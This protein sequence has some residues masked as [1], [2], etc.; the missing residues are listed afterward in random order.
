MRDGRVVIGS[1]SAEQFD[2]N[3][4]ALR[5]IV[6]AD[7]TARKQLEEA[8]SRSSQQL[9]RAQ[10]QERFRI[11][12]DL[13]D[14]IGQRL[15]VL[16]MGI[17]HVRDDCPK[18][19]TEILRRLAELS[20]LAADIST[21]IRELSHGL[22]SPKLRLLGIDQALRGLCEAVRA[23]LHL[24]IDFTSHDVPGAVGTEASLCLFRVLQEAL[25]NSAKHSGTTRVE[26]ELWG[27][28]NEIHLRIRDFGSG[29]SSLSAASGSGLG[30]LTMR[31]RVGMAGG[32]WS[33]TSTPHEGTEINVRVPLSTMEIDEPT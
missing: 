30:L 12:R 13:H 16:Q 27:T 8:F 29:F 25:N 24:A 23:Q 7:I 6:L 10:E 14:D 1:L 9:I 32:T 22:H 31:E 15:A 18:P 33:V 20:Q 19:T 28:S 26:V 17:D 4:D 5:I 3:G 2:V 11:A 21:D